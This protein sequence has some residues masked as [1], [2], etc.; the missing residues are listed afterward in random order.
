MR[1]IRLGGKLRDGGVAIGTMVMEFNS[2]GIGR[3]AAEAGADFVLYD[4]EH[5]GWSVETMRV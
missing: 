4:M 2:T 5:T 3:L 1:E